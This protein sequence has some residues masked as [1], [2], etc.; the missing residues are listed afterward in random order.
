LTV[1]VPDEGYSINTSCA[2]T[3]ADIKC[4]AHDEFMEKL[5]TTK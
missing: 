4:S 5:Y 3:N 2:N 1:S